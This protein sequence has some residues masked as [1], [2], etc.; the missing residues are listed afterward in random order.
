M[1]EFRTQAVF[2]LNSAG[3]LA[4]TFNY[5]N[6]VP[7]NHTLACSSFGPL[8]HWGIGHADVLGEPH[9]GPTQATV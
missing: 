9:T 4:S 6:F 2:T 5:S 1:Y 7:K 3:C 8:D